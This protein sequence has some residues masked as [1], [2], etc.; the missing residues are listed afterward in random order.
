MP[1]VC[2][3]LLA[4]RTRLAQ[5]TDHRPRVA[6]VDIDRSPERVLAELSQI[7]AA[8]PQTRFIV[9]SKEFD[10][11]LMLH[12]MRAGACHFLRKHAIATELAPVLGQL[13][14]SKAQAQRA[15]T[16]LSVFSCSGGCGATTVAINLANELRLASSK[17][18]LIV[19]LDT[20]YGSVAAHLDLRGKYG[21]AYLLG[22][23]GAVD[24]PLIES[25]AV[26]FQEGL[27][28][29]LSP[30][31]V[32]ADAPE[33]MNYGNLL[34]LLDACQESHAYVLVDAPR[35][36][37]P[38][39]ADLASVSRLAVVVLQLTVRDVAF[40]RSLTS[41]LID[42]G[43]PRDRILLLANRVRRRGPL[44][45]VEDAQQAIGID[46]FLCLRSDWSTAFRSINQGQPLANVAR[47]SGL[48]RD[49][50]RVAAQIQ[51]WTSNGDH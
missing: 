5:R 38:A 27:D 14:V 42:R 24:R 4:L 20:H 41:F 50:C 2:D 13:L 29:L 23:D 3:T 40:A 22:R 12:A 30:A 10:E 9:V 47:R 25:C 15:G 44:L 46:T 45:R 17:S 21:V 19:D 32:R 18:V 43:L 16:I 35:L 11:K 51:R 34:R 49:F 31:A 28:V 39:L 1:Q 8:D 37:Q 7:I 26:P 6:L 48:R 33:Q 36:P